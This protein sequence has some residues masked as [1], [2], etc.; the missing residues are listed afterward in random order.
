MGQEAMLC[1]VCAGNLD[2]VVECWMETRDTSSGPKV[3]TGFAAPIDI[4]GCTEYLLGV[5]E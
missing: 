4:Y 5:F 1:F 3:G 2:K